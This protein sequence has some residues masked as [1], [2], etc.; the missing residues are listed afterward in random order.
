MSD[1]ISK[2][3]ESVTKIVIAIADEKFVRTDRSTDRQTYIHTLS[4]FIPKCHELHSTENNK[5]PTTW[6]WLTLSGARLLIASDVIRECLRSP[7]QKNRFWRFIMT[8]RKQVLSFFRL[9][10][11]T[12]AEIKRQAAQLQQY[13]R[14]A[15]VWKAVPVNLRSW[16]MWIGRQAEPVGHCW[17]DPVLPSTL[18]VVAAVVAGLGGWC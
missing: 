12:K 10:F 3:A 6:L 5:R 8:V 9:R 16:Q 11:W 4:D 2:L 15:D 18:P 17:T 1:S 13:A 7:L 14:A